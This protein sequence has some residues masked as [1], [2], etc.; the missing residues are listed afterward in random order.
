M[1]GSFLAKLVLFVVGKY[2]VNPIAPFGHLHFFEGIAHLILQGFLGFGTSPGSYDPVG[3]LFDA[4]GLD[5]Y[6]IA[7]ETMLV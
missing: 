4:T 3:K 7:V 2:F 1:N 6:D 5:V